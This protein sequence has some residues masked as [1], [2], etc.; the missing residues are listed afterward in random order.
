MEFLASVAAELG[1]S[2]ALLEDIR[3]AN[4]ARHVL[5]LCREAGLIGITTLVCHKVAEHCTPHAGGG[6]EVWAISEAVCSGV[7][8]KR[9][10]ER[11]AGGILSTMVSGLE[12][13]FILDRQW[14][15]LQGEMKSH[16]TSRPLGPCSDPG[17]H[18]S[19]LC[20]YRRGGTPDSPGRAARS[21][22]SAA[23]VSRWW[24]GLAQRA[25]WA[26]GR[27]CAAAGARRVST[28]PRREAARAARRETCRVDRGTIAAC[29]RCF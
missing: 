24:G 26:P 9:F 22:P 1:G 14:F 17:R 3:A 27:P 8:R 19:V 28:A 25:E 6:L 21:A 2:A 16:E 20:H 10:H 23:I 18:G 15:R 29:P 4:T 12:T 7:T 13:G 11:H 5:D